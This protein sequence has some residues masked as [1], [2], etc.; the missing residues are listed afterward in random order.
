[1]DDIEKS[2]QDFT[3]IILDETDTEL[4][5]GEF[6]VV[7]LEAS[8]SKCPLILHLQ[9]EWLDTKKMVE[10]EPT[11]LFHENPEVVEMRE[12]EQEIKRQLSMFE[13]RLSYS[14]KL[15][16]KKPSIFEHE[17]VTMSKQLP[18]LLSEKYF[19]FQS[20]SDA[21][22]TRTDS[23]D[24]EERVIRSTSIPSKASNGHYINFSLNNFNYSFPYYN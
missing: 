14:S 16:L 10:K 19:K 23:T 20:D 6:E 13:N 3:D 5:L 9:Q 4:N 11:T 12:I 22:S 21:S 7:F 2:N 15:P 17:D 1:M 8:G 18:I 24:L